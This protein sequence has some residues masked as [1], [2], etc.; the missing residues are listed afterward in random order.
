M[1]NRK[2]IACWEKI[3][4]SAKTNPYLCRECEA[5]LKGNVT[6]TRLGQI[7]LEVS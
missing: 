4:K 7:L 3:R 6:E 1:K 2:C 5:V